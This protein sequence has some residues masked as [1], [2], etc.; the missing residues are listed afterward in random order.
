MA[1]ARDGLLPSFFSDVNK[2]TQVPVKST[3]VTGI[4]AAA[5]ALAMDVSQL[6]GMVR[7]LL[8]IASTSTGIFTQNKNFPHSCRNYTCM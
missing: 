3:I 1:M 5:L 2:Q 6:A 4:C 8:N 7:N